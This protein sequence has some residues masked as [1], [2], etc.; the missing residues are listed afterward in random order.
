M[1]ACSR[2]I[3]ELALAHQVPLMVAYKEA[4]QF[5][6]LISYGPSLT[7]IYGRVPYYV[8]KILKGAKPADLPIEQP[9]LFESFIN[10]KTAKS[11]GITIPPTVLSRADEVIE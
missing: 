11:L 6:A 7:K 3:A 1:M 9:T 10:A 4:M 5:G 2:R 8:D